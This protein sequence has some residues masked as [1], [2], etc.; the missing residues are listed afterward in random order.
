MNNTRIG[1]LTPSGLIAA[2][3]TIVILI[4]FSLMRGGAMFSPGA[5]NAQPGNPIEGYTSHAEFANTCRLCHA[6]FWDSAGMSGRCETC[7][8]DIA[9]QRLDPT[10]LH[11]AISQLDT[12]SACQDC[13]PDHRGPS[14]PLTDFDSG[15]FPHDILGYSLAGHTSLPNGS[16]FSCS[17]CHAT[18]ITTFNH[19][20]CQTCHTQL[21]AV[22]A[23]A[24]LLSFGNDC[25]VCH[26]GLDTYGDDFDHTIFPFPLTGQHVGAP[27]SACH[28]D[29]R[30]IPDL[31][32][33]PADCASCHADDDA[34]QGNLGNDCAACH[35]TGGWSPS[36]FDHSLSIFKLEGLHIEVACEA[37]HI[38]DSFSGTPTD[39]FSCHSQDDE[40][41]GRFTTLCGNLPHP[42]WLDSRHVRS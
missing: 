19:A 26:D 37:C 12:G 40:H 42:G 21:D 6:P 27:C 28:L 4:A 3:L 9:D 34:H 25:L 31:R 11:G 23:T 29:A 15:L 20:S 18:D 14:A 24:H 36:I 38:D 22:F 32:A 33:A 5:L 35:T 10:S 41:Q 16:S 13:H 17:D 30:T 8:T 1:C 7:H 39:C 2:G